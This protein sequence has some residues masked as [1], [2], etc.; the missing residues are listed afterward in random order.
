VTDETVPA[1]PYTAVIDAHNHLGESFGDGWCNKPV[2]ALLDRMAEAGVS[3]YVDLDGGWSEDILNHRLDKFKATY[4]DKFIFFGGPGWKDWQSD[5]ASFGTKSA[6]R[7]AAQVARGAQG[8]KIWKDFGLHVKDHKGI[9]AKIDDPALDPLWV[10]AGTQKVPV[11]IHVADPV[12]FFNPVDATNERFEELHAHPDWHFPYPQFPKFNELI[13]AFA[14]LVERHP[15]TTFIGA[16]VGCYAENLTWVS[17]LLDRCPN[18][19]IDFSAR[20]AEL[21]RKPYTTRNFMIKYVDRI[22]FGIDAGPDLETYRIYYRFLET[23]DEYFS[24]STEPIPPQGRWQIYGLNLP[25]D[26]LEKIYYKNA[27]IL[28]G[29]ANGRNP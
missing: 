26:V 10:E 13:E 11:M 29:I 21:G 23:Q 3:A 7:F 18:L 5:G 12:A 9:L 2:P 28:F 1:L 17:A 22:L 27:A 15:Q 19:M 20:I 25:K 4:P 24:Y 14:R 16:H 6:K 8:L